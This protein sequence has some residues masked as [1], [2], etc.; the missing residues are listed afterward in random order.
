[1]ELSRKRSHLRLEVILWSR[2]GP[3][4][5]F[6]SLRIRVW[7]FWS[8]LPFLRVWGWSCRV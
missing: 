3:C 8:L 2:D 4:A 1:M 5:I 6:G 7:G